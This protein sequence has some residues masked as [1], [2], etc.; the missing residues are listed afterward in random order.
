MFEEEAVKHY[1]NLTNSALRLNEIVKEQQ[2]K[3]EQLNDIIED[4]EIHLQRE[5]DVREE[6]AELEHNTYITIN[7][8]LKKVLS[9]FKERS[10][11]WK[12]H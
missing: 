3:I 1:N 11:R 10:A 9:L 4:F 7:D 6:D 12:N 8:T 2:N 5:I